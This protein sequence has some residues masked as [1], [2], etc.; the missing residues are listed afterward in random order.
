M[1]LELALK[2]F[3]ALILQ[4]VRSVGHVGAAL[5]EAAFVHVLELGDVWQHVDVVK[6]CHHRLIGSN[7]LD[8]L[9]PIPV[10][11]FRGVA[12]TPPSFQLVF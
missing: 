9:R 12:D 4:P 3:D 1:R 8:H 10:G 11:R 7:L 6:L 5:E 2:L